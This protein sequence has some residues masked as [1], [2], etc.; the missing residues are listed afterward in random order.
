MAIVKPV[1]VPEK[2]TVK[3]VVSFKDPETGASATVETAFWSLSDINGNII[4]NRENVEIASPADGSVIWLSGDDFSIVD[5]TANTELRLLAIYATYDNGPTIVPIRQEFLFEV[6]NNAL[7]ATESPAVVDPIIYTSPVISKTGYV[8]TVDSPGVW[9]GTAPIAITYQWVSGVT[10]IPG[11][12]SASYTVV[13]PYFDT[14]IRCDV[15]ATNSVDSATA[16]SNELTVT[17]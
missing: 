4:N 10:N 16:A 11:A 17:T 2:S 3:V 14:L 12:T 7:I 15:T 1:K 9:T 5:T 6:E 13:E 8:V